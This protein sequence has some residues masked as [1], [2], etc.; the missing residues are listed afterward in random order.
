MLYSYWTVKYFARRQ[1]ESTLK[2]HFLT[3][4]TYTV[5]TSHCNHQ[6]SSL[7]C[8]YSWVIPPV[9]SFEWH[10]PG[11]FNFSLGSCVMCM[12]SN[13]VYISLMLAVC[14]KLAL[15][16]M[17][18]VRQHVGGCAQWYAAGKAVEWVINLSTIVEH[19]QGLLQCVVRI[20]RIF[21]SLVS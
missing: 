16:G 9:K 13:S 20:C 2:R 6:S 12:P 17:N 7:N 14:L 5:F 18:P 10:G 8:Q 19:L 3:V 15:V 11:P 21:S 1:L 4:Y